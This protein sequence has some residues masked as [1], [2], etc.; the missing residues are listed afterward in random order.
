MAENT[1]EII[2]DTLLE[3]ERGREYSHRLI[4]AVLDKYDYLHPQEKAFMKRVLEGTTE[5]KLE[6]DYVLDQYSSV[7]VRRMKPLIRCLLRMSVYQILH[8]DGIPDSA[9]CNEAVKLAAKRRFG[10]LKGFVNGVLRSVVSNRDKLSWPDEKAEPLKALSVRYSMPEWIVSM[11]LDEYGNDITARLLEGLLKIHPVSIRFRASLDKIHI[12]EYIA[13]MEKSGVKVTPSPYLACAYQLDHVEGVQSLPGYE[14]GA[15]MVQDVS[16]MLAVEAAGIGP[17]D[18]VMDICAA[19]GGK[20][21][22]ASEKAAVVLAGDVSASKLER[23]EENRQRMQ[24]DNISL[25]QWD[26]CVFDESRSGTADVL[27]LD[28]PCSGLGVM[29]KKR[30]IKYNVSQES[31]AAI[32]ELQKKIVENSWQYVKPGGILFYST[33]TIRREENEEMCRWIC[34][35]FPFEME[36]VREYLPSCLK[37]QSRELEE[38]MAAAGGKTAAEAGIQLMPG[39]MDTDGFYFARL[40]RK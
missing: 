37:K 1:R 14:E 2:L 23:M 6:L 5:R 18:T 9:A 17:E 40:R 36:D 16:S 39:Y 29:G 22:L 7:P 26:G 32:L 20:S 34:R 21:L 30:D 8:M 38:A 35:E 27:L 10:N 3:M 31:L 15:F 33:C 11:W 4:K 28:V 24:A 13:Q 25:S 19:P 12:Q